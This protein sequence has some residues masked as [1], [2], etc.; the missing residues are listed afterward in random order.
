MDEKMVF[1]T[2]EMLMLSWGASVQRA[3]LYR[4]KLAYQDPRAE[5]FRK[6]VMSFLSS[7][8]LPQYGAGCPES[9][10]YVNLDALVG[11]ANQCDPGILCPDGYKYGI[12]QKLLNLTLKYH[13]CMGIIPAPPHC[14]VDRI[15][16]SKTKYSGLVN[17]TRI[18][19]RHEYQA[20]IEEI[21]NLATKAEL[22]VPVWELKTFARR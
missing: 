9:S 22:S 12:A 17:W 5:I 20:V 8:I 18:T 10:H 6:K 1:L 3:C 15:I 19:S 4:E 11:F 7:E 2:S 21:K 14:P 16:I 13:W